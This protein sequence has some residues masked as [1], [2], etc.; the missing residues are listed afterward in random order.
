MSI[1]KQKALHSGGAVPES[2]LDEK[3]RQNKAKGER[4]PEIQECSVSVK[5]NKGKETEE[6]S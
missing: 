3:K 2:L 1:N 4:E 6:H 5:R